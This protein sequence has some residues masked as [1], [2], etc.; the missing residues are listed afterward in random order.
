[1]PV[2]GHRCTRRIAAHSEAWWVCA[3]CL[4][5]FVPMCSKCQTPAPVKVVR[6]GFI[7]YSFGYLCPTCVATV[8]AAG[9]WRERRSRTVAAR[10]DAVLER[11]P[12]LQVVKATRTVTQLEGALAGRR[13][14]LRLRVTTRAYSDERYVFHVEL[15][16]DAAP[17][18][19]EALGLPDTIVRALSRGSPRVLP[20]GPTSW[21][22]VAFLHLGKLDVLTVLEALIARASPGARAEPASGDRVVS[23]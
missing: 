14:Q 21:L 4:P 7:G 8:Q 22:R 12:Q 15:D 1:M 3:D 6:D 19:A 11:Y 17:V 5:E 16:A 2:Y 18:T 13:V 20:N 10:R 9:P 23:S